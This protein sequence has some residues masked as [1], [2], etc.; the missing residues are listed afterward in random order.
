MT[1]FI[2]LSVVMTI[3]RSG[4]NL[5]PQLLLQCLTN[6]HIVEYR[7]H[8]RMWIIFNC[9]NYVTI[10]ARVTTLCKSSETLWLAAT[11]FSGFLQTSG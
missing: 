10:N 1:M 11:S 5:L 6:F 3:C 9:G 2:T 8:H 7:Y 4:K